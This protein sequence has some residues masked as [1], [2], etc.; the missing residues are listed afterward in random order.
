MLA[1]SPPP[2]ITLADPL[3]PFEPFP[4]PAFTVMSIKNLIK[5]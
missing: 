3:H 4:A 1:L 2:W 5:L